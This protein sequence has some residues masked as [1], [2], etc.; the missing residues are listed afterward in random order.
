MPIEPSTLARM[1]ALRIAARSAP[2]WKSA[3]DTLLSEIRSEFV[4]DNEALYLL[5]ARRRNLEVA[6][7]RA[8]GRGRSHE[9]DINWGEALAGEVLAHNQ[10]I[11]RTP[12]AS[13][14]ADRLQRSFVIGLPSSWP[15]GRRGR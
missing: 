2:D 15:A 6:H 4:F 5:D 1:H 10:T 11:E 13:P 14:D 9:A 3:F 7:A 12:S 8:A